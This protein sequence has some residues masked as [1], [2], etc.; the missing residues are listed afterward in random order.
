MQTTLGSPPRVAEMPE[1][2]GPSDAWVL[3]VLE[4]DQLVEAKQDHYRRARLG[5]GIRAL[6]WGMR[7]YVLFMLVVVAYQV[8]TTIHPAGG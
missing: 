1:R 6:M 5:R 7:G 8:W 3:D 4:P 2:S